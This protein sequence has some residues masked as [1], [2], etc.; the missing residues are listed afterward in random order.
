MQQLH[1]EGMTCGH[2]EKTVR[3][4]LEKV[5]GVTAV[6]S[7]DR[8]TSSARVE[9]SAPLEALVSAVNATGFEAR[10]E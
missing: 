2:C 7:V 1:V 9:G 6:V 10:P 5:P 3:E 4:A 8:Q